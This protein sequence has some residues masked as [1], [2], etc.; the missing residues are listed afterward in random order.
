MLTVTLF[1]IVEVVVVL[2][3]VVMKVLSVVA[4][5]EVSFPATV[6]I[7]SV[8]LTL[9]VTLFAS[10]VVA[11]VLFAS[12]V[13]LFD[14]VVVALVLLTPTVPL[15][16]MVHDAVV[17]FDGVGSGLMVVDVLVKASLSHFGSSRSSYF[18]IRGNNSKSKSSAQP[19]KVRREALW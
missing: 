13:T 10:V 19:E 3:V 16:V 5:D 2:L 17:A 9:T 6:T 11:L 8:L 15:F 4:S 12:T 18:G 1:A 14:I 7:G